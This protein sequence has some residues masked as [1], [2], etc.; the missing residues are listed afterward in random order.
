MHT[1]KDITK[2][3]KPQALQPAQAL[4]FK[5]RLNSKKFVKNKQPGYKT[6]ENEFTQKRYKLLPSI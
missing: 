5:P 6:K 1:G 3:C 2:N 4:V